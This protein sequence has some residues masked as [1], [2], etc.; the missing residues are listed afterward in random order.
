M[1]DSPAFKDA[2]GRCHS[3]PSEDQEQNR[4]RVTLDQSCGPSPDDRRG[5][6]SVE[7]RPRAFIFRHI[8][9][10]EETNLVGN[11]YFAR[12]VAWQGICR[13]M[14]LRA[15]APSVLDEIACGLRLITVSVSCDYF[16]ELRAF[17]EIE[18]R[19][20]L[21]HQRGNRIGLAFEY[22]VLRDGSSQQ[23]ALGKQEI[24]CMRLDPKGLVPVSLPD[25][26]QAALDEF[27][28]A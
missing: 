24:G 3:V 11:V 20:S 28:A 19:M 8:V 18:L 17:D 5:C 15:H 21:E 23:C 25:E 22:L 27:S 10:F 2:D 1:I 6:A 7:S 16:A 13:E 12:H 26:L 14:F 9:S 4:T